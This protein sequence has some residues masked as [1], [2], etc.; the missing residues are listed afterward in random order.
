MYDEI[1]RS[2][3]SVF[4]MPEPYKVSGKTTTVRMGILLK[5][6]IPGI[7][8]NISTEFDKLFAIYYIN[9]ATEQLLVVADQRQTPINTCLS[10]VEASNIA[11]RNIIQIDLGGY[12][13]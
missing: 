10:F 8:K 5:Q 1:M 11:C 2:E 3:C 12:D 6:I 7:A 4:E 9:K 13:D